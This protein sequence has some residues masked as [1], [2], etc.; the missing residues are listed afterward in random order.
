[1]SSAVDIQDSVVRALAKYIV[2]DTDS[3]VTLEQAE[4]MVRTVFRAYR[5]FI[6]A[7]KTLIGD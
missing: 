1:M 2:A 7:M 3:E 5:A 6:L 4:K